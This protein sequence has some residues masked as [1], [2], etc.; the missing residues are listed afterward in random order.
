MVEPGDG[1]NRAAP[2]MKTP[3]NPPIVPRLPAD[4]RRQLVPE[5]SPSRVSSLRRLGTL[6]LKG[7]GNLGSVLVRLFVMAFYLEIRLFK[8]LKRRRAGQLRRGNE[9]KSSSEN[10][11]CNVP[12]LSE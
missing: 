10:P 4:K 12:L 6:I 11:V 7:A 5:E 2:L 1:L 9:I 3:W 8:S